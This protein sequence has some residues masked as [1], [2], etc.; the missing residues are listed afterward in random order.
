MLEPVAAV[1]MMTVVPVVTPAPM[2]G[3]LLLG[4]ALNGSGTDGR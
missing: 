2:S 4:H 3:V 1:P